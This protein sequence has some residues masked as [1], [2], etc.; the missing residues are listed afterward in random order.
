MSTL[1]MNGETVLNQVYISPLLKNK[2]RDAWLKIFKG[3]KGIPE[4]E[5]LSPREKEVLKLIAEGKSSKEIGEL[6]FISA[7]TVDHHRASIMNKLNLRGTADL[8]KYAITK[9]YVS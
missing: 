4:T 3:E 8:T 1:S 9:G 2:L 7:R 6:L 5:V